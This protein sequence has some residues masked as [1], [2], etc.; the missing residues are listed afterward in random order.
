MSLTF[1]TIFLLVAWVPLVASA[2][3]VYRFNDESGAPVFTDKAPPPDVE[4][5]KIHLPES[6]EVADPDARLERIN[7][8]AT[9]LRDD[10]QARE[11]TRA[12]QRREAQEERRA[13]EAAEA[14]KQ[15]IVVENRGTSYGRWYPEYYPPW[16]PGHRPG[17]RPKPPY[18]R[19]PRPEPLPQPSGGALRGVGPE[20]RGW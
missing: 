5:E 19:P 12:T 1:K 11:E 6:S 20:G 3:D 10:R 16:P 2:Q 8:T 13:R 7:E 18:Y 9:M 17:Y 4:S 15:P 14:A